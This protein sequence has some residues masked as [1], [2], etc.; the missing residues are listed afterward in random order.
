VSQFAYALLKGK[1]SAA[2]PFSSNPAQR[3]HY[4]LRVEAAGA[5][6]DVAVNIASEDPHVLDVRVLAAVKKGIRPA[7]AQELKATP[8]GVRN[9]PPGS[10]L[11]LDYVADGLVTKDEMALLPLYDPSSE[12][13]G[14]DDIMDLVNAAVGK[15]NVTVYAFGHRYTEHNPTNDAWG[16]SPDDGVHNI[17]MNQGNQPHNHDNENGRHQDGALWLH[18]EEADTWSAV[19]VA[20]QTQSWNN[21]P[22]GYPVG[23]PASGHSPSHGHG[24]GHG[25][26]Q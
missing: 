24:H 13:N 6:F 17:H 10:P 5:S 12:D 19:Y 7:H 18:D 2:K 25:H 1:V 22:D 11:R 9:L 23:A 16:F 15:A 8:E 14:A 20:F 3:P 26:G 4:H 21:G